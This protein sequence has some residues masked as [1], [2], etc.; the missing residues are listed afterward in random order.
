MSGRVSNGGG[1]RDAR[2]RRG[3][4]ARADLEVLQAGFER[5]QSLPELAERLGGRRP[6]QVAH[7]VLAGAGLLAAAARPGLAG[8]RV[9]R[10]L[11]LAAAQLGGQ[12]ADGLL[13]AQDGLLLLQHGLAELQHVAPE[14]LGAAGGHGRGAH[15]G[16]HGYRGADE[17]RRPEILGPAAQEAE[18][19]QRT[20]ARGAAGRHGCGRWDRA[21]RARLGS[22]G[23]RLGRGSAGARRAARTLGAAL[24]GRAVLTAAL[25]GPHCRLRCGARAFYATAGGASALPTSAGEESRFNCLRPGPAARLGEHGRAVGQPPSV[26]SPHPWQSLRLPPNPPTGLPPPGVGGQVAA[27]GSRMGHLHDVPKS[28][29]GLRLGGWEAT[30][31]PRDGIQLNSLGCTEHPRGPGRGRWRPSRVSKDPNR[32]PPRA[33]GTEPHGAAKS[34]EG[35]AGPLDVSEMS[36]RS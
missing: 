4:A 29:L 18:G 34:G 11:A 15:V 2:A 5:L 28:P 13:L 24:L 31:G 35:V 25:S 32:R 36:V 30:T 27:S 10:A 9:Q 19:E 20:G 14:L 3:T 6:G 8:A 23:A 12:L 16:V 7:G 26:P 33:G 17:A 21:L 1:Q 22:A